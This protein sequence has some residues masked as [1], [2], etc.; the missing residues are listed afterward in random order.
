MVGKLFKALFAQLNK[1][2]SFFYERDPIAIMKYEYE[3]ARGELKEGKDGLVQYRALTE[4]FSRDVAVK[5]QQKTNAEGKVS[6]YLQ[7]NDRTNAASMAVKL[8]EIIA[9][10]AALK[11]QLAM[12]ETSYQNNVKKIQ[13]AEKKLSELKDRTAKYEAELKISGAE[14]KMA[15]MAASFDFDSL[16]TDIGDVESIL[17]GKIDKNRAKVRVAADLSSEGIDEIKHDEAVEAALA[18][19]ALKEFEAGT[20]AFHEEGWSEADQEKV[21][22]SMTDMKESVTEKVETPTP[23]TTPSGGK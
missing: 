14:A 4:K 11:K 9:D 21:R 7:I 20:G 22:Q 1:I 18:E 19:N 23:T 15:E 13:H 6:A 8:K 2:V 3:R 12:H 16:T 10:L 17:Q 5:E